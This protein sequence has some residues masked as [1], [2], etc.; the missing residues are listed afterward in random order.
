MERNNHV[1][2]DI[3]ET[4]VIHVVESAATLLSAE[5]VNEGLKSRNT[6]AMYIQ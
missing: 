4:G 3:G 5:Q 1:S 6:Y 2:D